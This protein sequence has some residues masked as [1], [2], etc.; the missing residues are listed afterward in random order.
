MIFHSYLFRKEIKLRISRND[1]KHSSDQNDFPFLPIQEGNKTEDFKKSIR[2][3][4]NMVQNKFLD[5]SS[6]RQ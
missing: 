2:S 3:C 1:V 5:F 4:K 6:N